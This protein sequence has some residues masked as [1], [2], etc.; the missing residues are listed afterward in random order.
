MPGRE[1]DD[2]GHVTQEALRLGRDVE[3]VVGDAHLQNV[4]VTF[5]LR[6]GVDF[7]N[8]CWLK[9]GTNDLITFNVFSSPSSM[10]CDN[11]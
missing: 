11:H 9:T 8:S 4:K 2:L 5:V 3:I 1:R 7:H 6:Q 10:G